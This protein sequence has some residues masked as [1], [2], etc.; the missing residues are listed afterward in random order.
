MAP[1]KWGL[2]NGNSN[3]YNFNNLKIESKGQLWF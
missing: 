2:G 3:L 1:G